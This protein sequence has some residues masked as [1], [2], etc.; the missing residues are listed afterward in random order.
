M[1]HMGRIQGIQILRGIAASLVV[2]VHSQYGDNYNIATDLFSWSRL[3]EMGVD[4][5]FV[6]SGFIMMLVSDPLTGRETSPH[7]FLV[8]RIQRIVPLYWFYTL[9]LTFGAVLV[10]SILRWTT[11]TP[12]LVLK[13][14]FFVPSFHPVDGQLHPLLAQGWTLNYEMFFYLCFAVMIGLA[15]G[16][17]VIAMASLFV[18]LWGLSLAVGQDTA[19]MAFLGNT[20]VFEFVA[21]M[22]LYW[23]YRRGW[24]VARAAIPAAIALPILIWLIGSGTAAPLAA[25][26]DQISLRCI[27]WG[28]PSL[29]AVYVVLALPEMS[30]PVA[31]ALST[32]GD[33]SYSLYLCHTFVVAVVVRIW[34]MLGHESSLAFGLL[35]IL[36][37]C[38]A[39]SLLSYRLIE[40]PLIALTRRAAGILT[41]KPAGA[42]Q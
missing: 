31:R 1:P 26:L 18:A 36:P 32:L 25:G 42:G 4:L 16:T 30:N 12:S 11:L 27:V 20:I 37:C 9:L 2:L 3:F 24:V 21:G 41:P 28:I 17:R 10:P 40:R 15:L 23:V 22:G 35:V 13:S 38:I 5:F 7:H 6:T 33:A 8:R 19:F 29:L 14:L 39:V 34:R